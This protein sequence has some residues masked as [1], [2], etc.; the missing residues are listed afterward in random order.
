MVCCL[1]ASADG[2]LLDLGCLLPAVA[3][4]AVAAVMVCC[5]FAVSVA[6]GLSLVSQVLNENYT[7]DEELAAR[8]FALAFADGSEPEATTAF[9]VASCRSNW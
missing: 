7:Q 9:A 4:L 3:V 6:V 2:A 8:A 1:L 5:V